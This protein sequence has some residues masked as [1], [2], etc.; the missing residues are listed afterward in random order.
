[1]AHNTAAAVVLALATHL[2]LHSSNYDYYLHILFGFWAV[3]FSGLVTAEYVYLDRA[4]TSTAALRSTTITALMYFGT[5]ISS[6]LIY[7]GFFHRLR[8]V[9]YARP[10]HSKST[11]T[12]LRFR[13][14]SLRA[15]QN[16]IRSSPASYQTTSIT[17]TLQNYTSNTNQT[18]SGQALEKSWSSLLMPFHLSMGQH[19]QSGKVHGMRPPT[20]L[21]ESQH[22]QPE[23]RKSTNE[24]ERF[25]TT[26]SMR[27]HC[28]NTSLALTDMQ[29]A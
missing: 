20:T 27:N 2:V 16:F 13:A 14:P 21:L 28:V 19:L 29:L 17:S 26:R 15:S 4:Q 6:V 10:P 1:M 12:Y 25:G 18:L 24:D 7:R 8:I 11:L 9:R 3:A 22:I 5:L 23:I